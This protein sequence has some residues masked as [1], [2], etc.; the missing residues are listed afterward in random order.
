MLATLIYEWFCPRLIKETC[1]YRDFFDQK[2]SAGELQ[3][4]LETHVRTP[5]DE[6]Q[7]WLDWLNVRNLA[8]ISPQVSYGNYEAGNDERVLPEI[9]S[10]TVHA[11]SQLHSFARFSTVFLYSIGSLLLAWLMGQNIYYVIEHW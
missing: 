11:V 4:L 8:L 10:V 1:N 9:Y 3:Q 7:R 6:T 2:R 5:N